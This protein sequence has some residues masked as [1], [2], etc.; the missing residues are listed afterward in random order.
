MVSTPLLLKIAPALGAK[1][2]ARRREQAD[3]EGGAGIPHQSGHVIVFGFGIGGHLVS[4]AL[5]D[6]GVPYLILELNGATVRRARGDGEPI[7]YGDATSPES[8]HAA[9]L[10]GA[11]AVVSLL[12]DPD[13][14][15]RMVKAAR[16][17]SPTVP[18]VV[19]TRYRTE[20]DR[21]QGAGATVAVAEELEASLEVLA[22]LLARLNIAGNLIE[23]LLD[24]FRR[25]S[26]SL[27][28]LHAPSTALQSLPEAIQRMPVSTHRVEDHHWGCG[29]TI[30]E[31]DL[32]AKT[33]ASVI[34]IHR[35]DRY[36]TALS[37][38][39]RL[40]EGD[41]LYLVGDPADIMLA[42][43]LLSEGE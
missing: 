32:R 38:D 36:I 20:A 25:E 39:E 18:I 42:R 17:I 31:L 23:P 34:A 37:P 1:V 19:R 40:A 15:L 21:L 14:A 28:P 6:L 7:F 13:A 30:A 16:E 43:R 11:L 24:V 27:R 4:R 35:E 3:G 26:V 8:L 9:H 41:V 5:R 29:R 33:N 22:Q 2:A 10:D 12:S